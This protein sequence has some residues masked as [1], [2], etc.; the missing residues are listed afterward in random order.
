MKNNVMDGLNNALNV[1]GELIEKEE[2]LP[3]AKS[4]TPMSDDAQKDFEYA[5]QNF[6][7]VIDK[8][9]EALDH[10]L[11][12]AKSSEH[13]RA[14]EVVSQLIKAIGDANNNLLDLQKKKKNLIQDTPETSNGTQVTNNT[15]FV[16]STSD[17]LRQI[18]E[19]KD[20]N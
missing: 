1:E 12:L 16:G 7:Q 10:L 20:G 3:P 5:R 13:P 8:G 9:N 11:E 19:E 17:L 4:I 15:L 2:V 14:F 18:R 6:H